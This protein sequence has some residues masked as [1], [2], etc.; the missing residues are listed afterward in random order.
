MPEPPSPRR[1]PSPRFLGILLWL[2]VFCAVGFGMVALGLLGEGGTETLPRIGREAVVAP[3][4][5]VAMPFGAPAVWGIV[6]T[7]AYRKTRH[8]PSPSPCTTVERGGPEVRLL[9]EGRAETMPVSWRRPIVGS[10]ET[11]S[12]SALDALPLAD[13]QCPE[14]EMSRYDVELHALRPGD[15][16][17]LTDGPHPTIHLGGGTAHVTDVAE[18][19]RRREVGAFVGLALAALF[20]LAGVFL[21]R[22]LRRSSSV[23]VPAP[24]ADPA[25]PPEEKRP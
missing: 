6:R 20:A 19:A 17:Y 9:V 13:V 4:P 5:T 23:P 8:S 22:R 15:R 10:P 14:G 2:C 24:A 12:T 3:Q 18:S 1:P 7:T 16:V 25:F 21:R 11:R